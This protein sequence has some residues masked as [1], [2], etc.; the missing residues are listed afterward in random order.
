[1]PSALWHALGEQQR[2][3]SLSQLAVSWSNVP[4]VGLSTT[5]RWQPLCDRRLSGKRWLTALYPSL[6]LGVQGAKIDFDPQVAPIRKKPAPW[7]LAFSELTHQFLSLNWGSMCKLFYTQQSPDW[8]NPPSW[9]I[10][11]SSTIHQE[12]TLVYICHHQV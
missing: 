1:M 7:A 4:Y 2:G 6:S 11:Q 10:S 8:F 9:L 12:I 3:W 5:L